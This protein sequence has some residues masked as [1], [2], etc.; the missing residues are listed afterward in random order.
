ML[1]WSQKA[2]IRDG[3]VPT[4]VQ[5]TSATE[6]QK[7]ETPKCQETST[8]SSSSV[9]ARMIRPAQPRTQPCRGR[10]EGHSGVSSSEHDAT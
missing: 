7:G 10:E 6:F 1:S 3:E 9:H 2:Q 8:H 5:K 4:V